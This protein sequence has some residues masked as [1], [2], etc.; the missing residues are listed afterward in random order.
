MREFVRRGM[1]RCDTFSSAKKSIIK[2]FDLGKNLVAIP[3]FCP[4]TMPH[5]SL[6]DRIRYKGE[7]PVNIGSGDRIYAKR[8]RAS[9]ANLQRRDFGKSL[10][11][12]HRFFSEYTCNSGEILVSC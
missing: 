12:F 6:G 10:Q 9:S 11:V 3:E 1:N 4:V 8:F 2:N 5:F 7:I